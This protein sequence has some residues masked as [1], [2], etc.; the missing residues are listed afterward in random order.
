MIKGLWY[1]RHKWFD[2]VSSLVQCSFKTVLQIV[3]HR[4]L[5]MMHFARCPTLEGEKSQGRHPVTWASVGTSFPLGLAL[6]P[7][8]RGTQVVCLVLE[9]HEALPSSIQ[10]RDTD[11]YYP[12]S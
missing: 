5:P 12:A 1:V 2:C 6:P 4:C 3:I 9:R 8:S 10:P 11:Y 7:G